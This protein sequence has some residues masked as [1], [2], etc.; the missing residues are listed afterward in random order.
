MRDL[1]IRTDGILR[2]QSW[3]V[4]GQSSRARQQLLLVH[5]I[6]FGMFYGAVMGSYG[7]LPD[8]RWKQV[9]YS[10]VKV[11]L[12]LFATVALSLPSFY[13]INMLLGLASDFRRA[14][15]S[16]FAAQATVA[17]VLASLAP[18]TGLFYASSSDYRSAILCNGVMFAVASLSGQLALRSYYRPLIAKHTKHRW[19]SALW[20]TMY[21]LVGI[22]MGW[23]LR[24]FIGSHNIET[25]FFRP[26]GWS[27]AYIALWELIF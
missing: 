4:S 25:Q 11:P 2:R 19:M 27:N 5:V 9:V 12:L 13:V 14:V 6:L 24:P 10:S 7:L 1:L 20:T 26:E 17:I 18:F 23:V 22:Q 8:W 15:R 3:T 16:I 21:I